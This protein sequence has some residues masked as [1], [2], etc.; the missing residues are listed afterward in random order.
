MPTILYKLNSIPSY[1]SSPTKSFF[2]SRSSSEDHSINAHLGM[3]PPKPSAGTRSRS[4][5]VKIFARDTF[6]RVNPVVI[7]RKLNLARF[8]KTKER[9][10]V[11]RAPPPVRH[12]VDLTAQE[13]QLVNLSV[14]RGQIALINNRL[15]ALYQSWADIEKGGV[16]SQ[17]PRS[18]L[19][20]TVRV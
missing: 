4:L 2:T 16:V 14:V 5:K 3:A 9:S 20:A 11:I 13:I 17:L 19:G 6:N 10:N 1:Q 7:H 15:T 18:T 8:I 12:T